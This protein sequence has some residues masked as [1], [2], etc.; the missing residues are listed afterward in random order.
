M[1]WLRWLLDRFGYVLWK[2]N[3]MVYG[4][5]PFLDIER[6]SRDW[7]IAVKIFFDV[8]ANVGQT[9][10]EALKQFPQAKVYSFEP[11]PVTFARLSKRVRDPRVESFPLALS[12]GEGQVAFFEYAITGG[13]THINSLVPNSSFPR[14]FGVHE[15]K[16]ITA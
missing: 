2:K 8:G 12:D 7:G 16:Q 14:H 13:G 4:V 11:H 6:L 1:R 3:F 10:E 15:P 9:A 5:L